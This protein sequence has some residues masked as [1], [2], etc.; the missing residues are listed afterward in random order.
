MWNS[1]TFCPFL[2]SKTNFKEISESLFKP[3]CSIKPKPIPSIKTICKLS[4]I[5]Q[6]KSLKSTPNS[7]K[8]INNSQIFN[9]SKITMTTNRPSIQSLK[10]NLTSKSNP[11]HQRKPYKKIPINQTILKTL[12][13]CGIKWTRK[14]TTGKTNGMSK[15]QI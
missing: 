9:I 13:Q 6:K 5:I 12:N 4:K 8:W 14:W 11:S 2:L 7:N 3:S 10:F 1:P 15:N